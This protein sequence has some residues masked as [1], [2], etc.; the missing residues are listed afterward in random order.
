RGMD[1]L[2][3]TAAELTGENMLAGAAPDIGVE[4]VDRAE[5]DRAQADMRRRRRGG[6]FECG[7]V[8][9]GKSIG[10]AGSKAHPRGAQ[11]EL[12]RYHEIVRDSHRAKLLQY[13]KIGLRDI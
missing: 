13:R 9:I 2:A 4:Q 5:P 8:A 11:E 1:R 7:D 10:A 6:G 12:Q 3:V